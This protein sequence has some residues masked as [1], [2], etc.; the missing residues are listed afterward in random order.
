M[1]PHS[2]RPHLRR[3]LT[4]G[5]RRRSRPAQTA[6]DPRRSDPSALAIEHPLGKRLARAAACRNSNR[7]HPQSEIRLSDLSRGPAKKA[8]SGVKLSG[9]FNSMRDSARSSAGIR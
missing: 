1:T 8:P 3:A 9:P 5:M 6:E 7:V 2:V 4:A